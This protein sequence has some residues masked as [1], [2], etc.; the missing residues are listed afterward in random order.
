[1]KDSTKRVTRRELVRLGAMAGAT[2]ALGGTSIAIA[3]AKQALAAPAPARAVKTLTVGLGG[4]ASNLNTLTDTFAPLTSFYYALWDPA[5]DVR[6]N[7]AGRV[8]FVPVVAESWRV[9]DDKLTWEFKL[10]QGLK[11]HNGE[12]IDAEA[13]AFSLEWMMQEK[14]ANNNTKSRLNPVWDRVRAVDK[15]TVHVKTRI[16][17]V[18]TPNAFAEFM[19]V[20]P[21]HFQQVGA[22]R[23]GQSPVGSGPM[24][25]V[26]WARGQRIVL[27]RNPRYWREPVKFDRLVL[28]PIPE[29]A[30]RVAALE[31]GEL[32]IAFNVP[33]DSTRRL[34]SRGIR[35]QWAPLGQGMNLT[36]KL[37]IAS[38]ITDVRV[39]QAM[40]FAIDKRLV[41]NTV[42][43]G[44]GRE[45]RAQMAGPS[46]LGYNPN[47][48]PYPYDVE[49]AK[50]LLAE[51]GY[52]NGFRMDFDTSQ[53]RYLK[54]K[55]V[56]EFLVGEY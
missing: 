9:L 38:P 6:F 35:I 51:A 45:L 23:F 34:M 11:F 21:K 32:D 17:Y 18:L 24:R 54:Q 26:E 41:I 49:R 2:A 10:R 12:D 14:T 29:D 4:D 31:V 25:F 22:Q 19:P 56:S 37:T 50:R 36:T 3:G 5:I 43:G 33:P 53:G 20:P 7:R 48:L 16:P 30:T 40:N 15:Y 47:I 8:Q 13:F 55:E 1:M 27:E 46:A 28:R 39:R 42:M 52:P 44:Y